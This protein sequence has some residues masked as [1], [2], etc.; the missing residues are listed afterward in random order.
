MSTV[1][2]LGLGVMGQG[3]VVNLV[4]AGHEVRAW[5]RSGVDHLPAAVRDSI[6][7]APNVATAVAGADAVLFCLSDDAAVTD[8]LIGE[9]RLASAVTPGMLVIDLSTVDP[10]TSVKEAGIIADRGGHFLDAPVFGTRG[11]AMAG[12]LWIVVGGARA[13]FDR[14]HAVLAPM[15]ET[16]HYMGPTGSGTA[17]KLVG[18]LLVASQLQ[19]LAEALVLA[20]QAGLNLDDVIGVLDVTDFRTPIYSGVGRGVRADD[21]SV[22]F[23]LHLMLKDANLITAFADR[24]GAPIPTTSVTAQ[25]IAHAV[26][27]GL[28]DLNASALVKALA[29]RAG[30]DLRAEAG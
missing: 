29:A 28:G 26:A 7:P 19:A 16:L 2:F 20:R 25:Q 9:G 17:M 6:S 30:V 22:N 18:N 3:M 4:R 15:S 23:A 11:E 13:D 10:A 12:G 27:D 5:N 21:Y 1:A 8:L 14:A 24:C